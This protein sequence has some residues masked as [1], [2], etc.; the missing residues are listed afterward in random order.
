MWLEPLVL[1]LLQ[2]WKLPGGTLAVVKST[3]S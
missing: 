1:G 3:V 2:T